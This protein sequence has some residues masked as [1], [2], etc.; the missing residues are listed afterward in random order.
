MT[1]RTISKTAGTFHL[2]VDWSL[3]E[4]GELRALRLTLRFVCALISSKRNVV[5]SDT[6]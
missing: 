6:C 2:D 1:G 5:V 4:K 3:I